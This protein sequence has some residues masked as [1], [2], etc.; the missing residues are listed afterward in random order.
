M[1]THMVI[2]WSIVV[3]P[4]QRPLANGTY[5]G[6]FSDSRRSVTRSLTV[7]VDRRQRTA[8]RAG[9]WAACGPGSCRDACSAL[10]ERTS[11]WATPASWSAERGPRLVTATRGKV[12]PWSKAG[13]LHCPKTR[14]SRTRRGLSTRRSSGSGSWIRDGSW[15]SS[16]ANLEPASD[17]TYRCQHR[18]SVKPGC[19]RSSRAAWGR[20]PWTTP[21]RSLRASAV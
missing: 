20:T 4:L 21:A 15:S 8:R 11:R 16:A 19:R 10:T 7:T 12:S 18:F 3:R 5:I 14:C 6:A 1:L 9:F 2:A 13:W 17:T